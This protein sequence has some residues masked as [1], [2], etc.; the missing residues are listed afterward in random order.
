MTSPKRVPLKKRGD[1]FCR[2]STKSTLMSSST[3]VVTEAYII[4]WKTPRPKR[5]VAMVRI[6]TGKI[7]IR[8]SRPCS[9]TWS[10][11]CWMK[12]GCSR[13]SP[14]VTISTPSTS[15]RRIW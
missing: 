5:M 9:S 14:V 8:S 13:P 10:I 12:K 2:C 11:N 15:A 1:I 3:R 4:A 6:A 7:Q